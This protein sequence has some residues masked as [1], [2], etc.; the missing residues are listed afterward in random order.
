MQPHNTYFICTTPHSGSEL[1]CDGLRQSGIAGLPTEHFAMLGKKMYE[2]QLAVSKKPE[3]ARGISKQSNAYLS[4]DYLADVFAYGTSRNGVFGTV[5]IWDYFD[6]FVCRLR[7]ISAYKESPVLDLLSAHFPN[8]H[9]IWMTRRDKERQATALW[10]AYQTEAGMCDHT[11]LPGKERPVRFEIIERLA[12]GIVSDEAD[13]LSF[14]KACGIQ[15]IT[16]I[17]EEFI[18]SYQITLQHLLQDLCIPSPENSFFHFN[19]EESIT[20]SLKII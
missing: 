4:E 6:D 20:S 3:I 15:P 2:E 1:L 16:V 9:F 13:W 14:F 17:Y 8:L 10:R 11:L 12:L 5:V 19:T 7:Q 18:T